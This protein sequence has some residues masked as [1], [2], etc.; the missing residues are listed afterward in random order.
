MVA[1]RAVSRVARARFA[2]A[3]VLRQLRLGR[4]RSLVQRVVGLKSDH[5]RTLLNADGR[6][7]SMKV[8]P[9]VGSGDRSTVFLAL[10]TT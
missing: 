9:G 1:E 5:R 2:S 7:T 10:D 8:G 3:K 6:A 4:Q